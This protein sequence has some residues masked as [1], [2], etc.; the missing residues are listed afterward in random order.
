MIENLDC[1]S[2]IYLL[3]KV[4]LVSCVK[5][6]IFILYSHLIVIWALIDFW[7][8]DRDTPLYH[9][10]G[11]FWSAW[12]GLLG[13]PFNA[14]DLVFPGPPEARAPIFWIGCIGLSWDLTPRWLIGRAGV[15]RSKGGSLW[16]INCPLI[17]IH[18]A[19][20]WSW[21]SPWYYSLIINNEILICNN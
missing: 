11:L 5:Q 18:L 15:G 6:F 8:Y 21:K 10:Q 9:F 20:P 13:P 2:V 12:F 4:S 3:I 1:F 7:G 19:S 14:R 17:P 16:P